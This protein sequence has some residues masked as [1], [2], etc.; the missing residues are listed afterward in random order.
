MKNIYQSSCKVPVYSCQ[1][2]MKLDFSRQTFKK[3]SNIKFLKN[4]CSGNVVPCGLTDQRRDR[5]DE[6]NRSFS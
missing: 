1:V 4:T 6:A 2:L 5:H 3:Y